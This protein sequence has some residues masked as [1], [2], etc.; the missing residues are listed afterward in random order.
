[1][2]GTVEWEVAPKNM[3][4]LAA[5]FGS[6]ENVERNVIYLQAQKIGQNRGSNY[7]AEDFLEGDKREGFQNDFI[8]ELDKV[9]EKQKVIV[10]TAFIRNIVIPES[11]LKQKRDRQLAIETTTTSEAKEAT[12]QSDAEVARAQALIPQ[13]EAEVKAETARLV[14][15]INQEK[16]N[17]TVQTDAEI[18]ELQSDYK[19]QKAQL[20]AE[21]TR[22]LGEAKASAARMKNTAEGSIH[23]MKLEAFQ[24]DGDAYLRA[25]LA[26]KLNPDVVLRLFQSGAG[27]FWT[28]LDNKS[29]TLMLPAA[30]APAPAKPAP[31]K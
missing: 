5:V 15:G 3:P 14:A 27:T 11:V 22:V 4:E 2:D 19:S 31:E 28:N 25:T 17:L 26:D 29:M 20:E 9:C 7:R 30:G 18:K 1:M 12:A 24:N 16:Q 8:A 23:K 6:R 21:K 10:R 13:A